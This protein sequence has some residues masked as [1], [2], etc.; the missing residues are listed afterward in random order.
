[1]SFNA[2]LLKK[3]AYHFKFTADTPSIRKKYQ[4]L[5]LIAS[6]L[7]FLFVCSVYDAVNFLSG[8][9]SSNLFLLPIC[10]LFVLPS[11]LFLRQGYDKIA[12]AF[13]MCCFNSLYFFACTVQ[14]IPLNTITG[15]FLSP[16]YCFLLGLSVKS[17]MLIVLLSI[18]HFIYCLMKV[19]TM[20]LITLND[21][22]NHQI[23]S[24]L[25]GSALNITQV[26]IICI[27]K[28][29]VEEEIWK[30]A[31]TYFKK[32]KIFARE[33][34]QVI[35]AKDAFFF[36]LS[37]DMMNSIVCTN[38]SLSYLLKV[39]KDPNHLEALKDVKTNF[40]LFHNIVSNIL[41]VSKVK[42]NQL[43]PSNTSISFIQTVER[44]L[45]AHAK[46]MRKKKISIFAYIEKGVPKNIW[47][48]TYWLM[49]IMTN[50]IYNTIASTRSGGKVHVYATWCSENSNRELLLKPISNPFG[51]ISNVQGRDGQLLTPNMEAELIR[52]GAL[53]EFENQEVRIRSQNLRTIPAFEPRCLQE[54][55]N[56]LDS[57][58]RSQFWE[59]NEDSLV[60][61]VSITNPLHLPT[62]S[63]PGSHQ[64]TPSRKGYLKIQVTDNGRTATVD[65]PNSLFEA[66]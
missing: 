61:S 42:Q 40:Q 14:K 63:A 39:I 27:L 34:K 46:L 62:S 43:T 19:Q 22:Q 3:F 7:L 9:V 66:I 10:I 65:D 31:D 35:E 56:S 26:C 64:L 29:Q 32:S 13:S 58:S 12:A 49:Q 25:V 4:I 57:S 54:A 48:D 5:F 11:F 15:L 53:Q 16:L 44:A 45:D 21:E 18:P 28:N 50:L 41:T 47:A 36:S 8:E 37:Q 17:I 59:I 30:V 38:E 55:G 52:Q 33:A 23:K 24:L 6:N 51:E 20:F 2:F 1:M 60:A